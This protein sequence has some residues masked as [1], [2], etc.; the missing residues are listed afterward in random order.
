MK[1]FIV[2]HAETTANVGR[3]IL[4]GKEHGELSERGKRQ[5]AGLA[6]RLSKEKITEIWCSPLTRA[7]QTAEEIA[8]A[9]ECKV[10]FADELRE[11][12][13]GSLTGLSHEQAEEK[14][15]RVWEDAFANPWRKLPGGESIGAVRDRAMPVVE[16]ILERAG[17]GEGGA[18]AIV[19][20]N[21][22]NRAIIASLIGLP[23]ERGRGI[24]IKNACIAL[25][26]ARPGFAQ[27]Y[28]LDNSLHGIR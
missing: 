10:F 16:R 23:L 8:K 19:G 22:V 17:R 14:Y 7:R 4:G 20:H 27:L 28:S 13:V 3:V 15:P 6:K 25:L 24:K 12:E 9:R 26:D 21:I 5:A 1:L 11:I 18:V 2:R